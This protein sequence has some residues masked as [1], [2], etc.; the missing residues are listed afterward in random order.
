[1]ATR[2]TANGW[3]TGPSIGPPCGLHLLCRRHRTIGGRSCKPTWKQGR[4][5]WPPCCDDLPLL[6]VFEGHGLAPGPAE[7]WPRGAAPAAPARRLPIAC[8]RSGGKVR[9]NCW[10]SDPRGT[11]S[12]G[13]WPAPRLGLDAPWGPL[14][15]KLSGPRRVCFGQLL[16]RGVATNRPLAALSWRWTYPPTAPL[17]VTPA[18]EPRRPSP[19]EP[20]SR[21]FHRGRCR[22]R[23]H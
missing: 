13:R 16:A 9:R 2:T 12:A 5:G 19:L 17:P 3:P 8:Q 7:A 1:M 22:A 11:L 18:L 21:R 23:R 14:P 10:P 15:R 20:G 6:R 4:S